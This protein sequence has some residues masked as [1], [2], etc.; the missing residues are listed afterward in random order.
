MAKK[1]IIPML[2]GKI[3]KKIIQGDQFDIAQF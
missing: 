3:T 1:S 2:E